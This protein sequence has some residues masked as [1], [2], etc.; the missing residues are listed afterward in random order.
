MGKGAFGKVK[1]CRDT[2]D[3]KQYAIKIMNK[4]LLKKK[5]QVD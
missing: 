1:L 5:R 3:N 2:R 4:A